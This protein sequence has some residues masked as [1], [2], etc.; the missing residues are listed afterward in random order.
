MSLVSLSHGF[1]LLKPSSKAT[2]P[3]WLPEPFWLALLPRARQSRR[4]LLLLLIFYFI[5]FHFETRI[6]Q[7]GLHLAI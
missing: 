3:L 7:G 4:F 5:F 6:A 2:H 1:S